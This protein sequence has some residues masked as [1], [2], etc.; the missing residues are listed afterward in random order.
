M[1]DSQLPNFLDSDLVALEERFIKVLKQFDNL[2]Q[3]EKIQI[4]AELDFF[5]ELESAGLTRV[6]QKLNSEYAG[7]I[8][9]L[10]GYKSQG[11][12]ALTLQDLELLV[13]ADTDS[14]L[15]SAQSYSSQ[16]R[17]RLIKGFIS[18]EQTQDI[19][20]DLRNIGLAKNQTISAINTARDQFNAVAV[21]KLFE[22]EPETRFKLSGPLDIKT[23]CSCRA[24]LTKQPK[25]GFTKSEIDKGAWHKIALANCADYAKQV[26]EG[27]PKYNFVNRGSFGC[28][29]FVEIVE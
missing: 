27:K 15:R 14:L 4:A 24:V 7:I 13:E 28:R 3:V 16:F 9:E 2:S 26:A 19:E 5:G 25:E 18:G 12:S 10:A 21:A 23:R 29:H 6:L 11:I 1:P 8:R 22:D 17:S 20:K